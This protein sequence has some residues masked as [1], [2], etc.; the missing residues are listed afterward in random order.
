[1]IK[2]RELIPGMEIVGPGSV[3]ITFIIQQVH[4]IWPNFQMV[5]WKLHDNSYSFDALDAE[6][7]VGECIPFTQQELNDNLKRALLHESQW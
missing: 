4:P 5:V 3:L 2:V 7:E 6:Q 1:M